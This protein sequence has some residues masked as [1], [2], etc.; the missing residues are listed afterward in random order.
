MLKKVLSI[1]LV[2]VLVVGL[3]ATLFIQPATATAITEMQA[4]DKLIE[5][6]KGMEGF[7]TFNMPAGTWSDD[8]SMTL[9]TLCSIKARKEIDSEDIMKRFVAWDYKGEYTPFGESFDQGRTC[10]SAIYN[11]VM[12]RDVNTC[13]LADEGSNGNGSLMRIMPACLFAYEKI[14]S[15]D[16][17]VVRAVEMIHQVSALTHAHLRSKIACGIYF[18]W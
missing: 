7:G 6:L 4:S 15:G 18:L 12:K 5:L 9:A 11:Y 1:A 17:T 10:T 2:A 8:G 13:G 16:I 3:A 14:K